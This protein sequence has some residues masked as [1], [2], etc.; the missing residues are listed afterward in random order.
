MKGRIFAIILAPTFLVADINP[1]R[2]ND[3]SNS[4]ASATATVTVQVTF[5]E[6]PISSEMTPEEIVTTTE[7]RCFINPEDLT[8]I[9]CQ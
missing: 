6:P 8:E 5:V 7:G 1:P 2:I 4:N 9:L 3:D